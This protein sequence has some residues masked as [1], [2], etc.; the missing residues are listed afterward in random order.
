VEGTLVEEM[1]GDDRPKEDDEGQ[2]EDAATKLPPAPPKSPTMRSVRRKPTMI[3]DLSESESEE[4]DE[5]FDAVDAGQ[6]QI[7]E[8]PADEIKPKNQDIVVSG[9]LDLSSSFQGYENGIRT[10]LKMDADD[11]PKISLWVR[12]LYKKHMSTILT[13]SRAFSSP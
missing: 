8:L 10:K 2:F 7:S 12:I 6:V 3:V 1:L 9:G 11:R 4:E 13:S 5:F